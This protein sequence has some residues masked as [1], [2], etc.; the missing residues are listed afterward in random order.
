MSPYIIF[1]HDY[2]CDELAMT[3]RVLH[4][5]GESQLVDQVYL[6][7]DVL[8]VEWDELGRS[9]FFIW[10]MWFVFGVVKYFSALTCITLLMRVL[11]ELPCIIMVVQQS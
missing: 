5:G 11:E 7:C 8:L 10:L 9:D 1:V 2:E 3:T 6:S 4:F